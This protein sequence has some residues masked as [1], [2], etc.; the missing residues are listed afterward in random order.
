[1]TVFWRGVLVLLLALAPVSAM[2]SDALIYRGAQT[3]F[4]NTVWDGEILI[5]GI[6]TVAAGDDAGNPPR[7]QGKLHPLRQQ[8]RR[9]R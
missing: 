7:K 5:D 9:H 2:S 1:M 8:R 4:E 6:L 3:I